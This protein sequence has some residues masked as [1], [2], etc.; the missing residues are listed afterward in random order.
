MRPTK[1]N[2]KREG[3]NFTFRNEVSIL[4]GSLA[5]HMWSE[6][7]GGYEEDKEELLGK[8]GNEHRGKAGGGLS[9]YPSWRGVSR[10]VNFS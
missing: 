5:G 8:K 10:S 7:K 2:T 1:E 6:K 4:E 9:P 3:V